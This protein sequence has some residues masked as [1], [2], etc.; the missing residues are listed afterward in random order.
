M[1]GIGGWGELEM[2][3]AAAAADDDDDGQDV[4][5]WF[6]RN[7]WSSCWVATAAAQRRIAQV[8]NPRQALNHG[9]CDISGV[10]GANRTTHVRTH[11][12]APRRKRCCAVGEPKEVT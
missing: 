8:G 2:I 12:H 3:A 5:M 6:A 10:L 4:V 9:D 1:C 11:A 7:W